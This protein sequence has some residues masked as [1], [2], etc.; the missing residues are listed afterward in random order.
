MSDFRAISASRTPWLPGLQRNTVG[1]VA[2]RSIHDLPEENGQLLGSS[3]LNF[4]APYK[5]QTGYV[6]AKRAWGHGYATESL[7]AMTALAP[8]CG[9]RRL[10]AI[11]HHAHRPSGAWYSKRVV[12]PSKDI[13]SGVVCGVSWTLTRL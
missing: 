10:Y 3:G 9:V 8:A 11:R 6:L 13:S 2:C 12:L 7:N 4:D 5:A 1:G